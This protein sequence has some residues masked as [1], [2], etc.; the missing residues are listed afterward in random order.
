MLPA[1]C[2]WRTSGCAVVASDDERTLRDDGAVIGSRP[3]QSKIQLGERMTLDRGPAWCAPIYYRAE[4]D[5]FRASSSL[6]PLVKSGDSVDDERLAIGIVHAGLPTRT[7]F[8]EIRIVPPLR[9][10][11]VDREGHRERQRETPEIKEHDGTVDELAEEVRAHVFD[12]VREATHG[13]KVAL[14]LS[15]GL[16][17][18]VVFATLWA[19][20]GAS[21]KDVVALTIDCD[22]IDDRSYVRTMEEHFGIHVVRVNPRECRGF[23]EKAL[24]IDGAPTRHPFH[25]LWLAC[26]QAAREHG[27]E[28]LVTGAGGDEFFGGDFVTF[29]ASLRRGDWRVIPGAFRTRFSHNPS[30]RYRLRTLLVAVLRPSMPQSLLVYRA[31]RSA[32]NQPAW[33]GPRLRSARCMTAREAATT[34]IPMSATD[35]YLRFA[36]ALQH[37][38]VAEESARL[39]TVMGI[40]NVDPFYDERLVRLMMSISPT[41]LFSDY[42]HRGLLRRSMRGL[43]PERIRERVSKG[44]FE[45]AY[46]AMMWPPDAWRDLLRFDRLHERGIVNRV[47]FQKYLAPLF[48]NPASDAAGYVWGHF[49]GALAAEK[50][51]AGCM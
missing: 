17:S 21:A 5:I 12:A 35:R 36:R 26:A 3:R 44:R 32:R 29:L 46:A 1:T 20:R 6:A 25:P 39:R 30:L 7:V 38:F 16:D 34:K 4:K 51:L 8:S 24:I 22:G 13:R 33:V 11:E 9:A 40:D 43:L 31:M 37:A 49:W 19:L 10:I 23:V 47:E 15:G 42:H 45:S 27:A 48:D 50:F 14:M 28:I 18:S 41:R 2:A